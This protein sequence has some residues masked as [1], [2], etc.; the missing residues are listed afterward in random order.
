MIR[1]STGLDVY[2]NGH[3]WDLTKWARTS[4]VQDLCTS[5]ETELRYAFEDHYLLKSGYDKTGFT[6]LALQRE[7]HP[8]WWQRTFWRPPIVGYSGGFSSYENDIRGDI[9]GHRLTGKPLRVARS[10]DDRAIHELLLSEVRHA[11]KDR[12]LR[13]QE[14]L[15]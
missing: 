8:S 15:M 13:T 6:K 1:N 4:S 9:Q 10:G 14:P 12:D 7:Q 3:P 2:D 11:L 5:S